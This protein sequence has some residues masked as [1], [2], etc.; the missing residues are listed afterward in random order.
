M[1]LTRT[2]FL[3]D[4]Y[5]YPCIVAI[6]G[7]LAIGRAPRDWQ[8]LGVAFLAGLCAWTLLEYLVHRWIFHHAPWV[9]RQHAAHHD[10]PKALVGTPTW[11]SVATLSVVVMLPSMVAEG[12]AIGSSFSAGLVL[13]YLWYCIVHYGV[14]HWHVARRGY[15]SRMKRRHAIHHQ[16]DVGSNFGV[17]TSVWDRL[18][19][20]CHRQVA[21]GW[22]RAL[23][24]TSTRRVRRH[25]T[26]RP[27][28]PDSGDA[29]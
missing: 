20:T 4:F 23:G 24:I 11:L 19:G 14:H 7:A 1:R 6:L 3:A 10:D 15:F 2:G 5:V 29:R 21:G 26:T 22:P 25:A 13:G 16:V 18:F 8:A 9:R 28:S 17:T 12:L 27:G